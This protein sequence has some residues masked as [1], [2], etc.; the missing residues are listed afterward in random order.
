MDARAERGLAIA[1]KAKITR[2]GNV[3]LV[4]SQSQD[5]E[6]YR[7]IPG[8][9]CTCPD[10]E[11]RQVKCKHLW[12]VEYVLQREMEPNGTV[13]ETETLRVTKVTRKTYPQDWAAYNAAQTE[14]KAHFTSLLADLC[15]GVPQPPPKAT[16]RPRLPLSEMLFAS[17]FKVY[18]GFSARR[19]TSDLRDA[20]ADGLIGSEPHFNSV[21]NYLA[22]AELTPILKQLIAVSSLPLKAIETD[23]AVDSS[24]FGTS[25][26]VKW[27]NKKYGR[28]L[29]NREWVK[30]HL[31]CGVTTHTVTSA[32]ISG[33]EA[34]DTS[35]FAPLLEETARSFQIG[36][37][38]GDKAYLSH[39]NLAAVEAVGGTPFVP[40]KVNTL[41]TT[42][43]SAWGRMY[44][45][46]MFNRD[47]F[48]THYH[49]RSNVETTF[50]M[51]KGKFGD[52]VRSKGDVAMVN[53][54]LCKVLCHNI[55]VVIQSLHELGIAE[56]T[57]C[58]Q[59]GP[60]QK[61]A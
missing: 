41:P 17:A 14:E 36:E 24:G 33:W 26:F 37:V 38:S 40:F 13:T 29:D 15:K 10:H 42:E 31:M 5:G 28:E 55:C 1:A 16:G 51:I 60:A 20:K 27:F 12:A 47:Q 3:W 46:F 57:F 48:L 19:F 25:R 44:H 7:V 35:F 22:S 34:N 6:K 43:A 50:S 23:F 18:S 9:R 4:P 11:V 21:S 53:E 2:N 39:R 52:A 56:P 61:L 49:K 58:A 45:Y 59:L 32:D 8:E 30:V 54:V